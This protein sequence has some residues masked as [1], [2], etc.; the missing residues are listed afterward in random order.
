MVPTE[1][2][3]REYDPP[4][5]LYGGGRDGLELPQ[6]VIETAKQ[7]LVP[8]GWLILEHAE[9]QGQ[10][11]R[12]V[13]EADPALAEASTHQDLSGRDRATSARLS[14]TAQ[15]THMTGGGAAA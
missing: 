13:C 7:V 11:L 3:V 1:Q 14:A 12:Q 6:A 15:E 2:E 10:A 5:A 8:G 4:M 9:T